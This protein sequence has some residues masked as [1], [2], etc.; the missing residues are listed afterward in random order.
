MLKLKEIILE[1]VCLAAILML[2]G[3]SRSLEVSF[4]ILDKCFKNG[5]SNLLFLLM[6]IFV[7]SIH[8]YPSMG[9]GQDISFDWRTIVS[10]VVTS[11]IISRQSW[12]TVVYILWSM[13]KRMS[14]IE[15]SLFFFQCT[16]LIPM[17]VGFYS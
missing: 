4:D 8:W 14:M 12:M 2:F 6:L 13:P 17:C 9:V 7:V 1:F 15:T 10:N 11:E 3:N 5:A 16:I